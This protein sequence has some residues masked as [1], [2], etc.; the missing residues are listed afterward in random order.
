[1]SANAAPV[2]LALALLVPPALFAQ[3]PSADR[4]TP[5]AP[6][7]PFTRQEL[8]Q[9][10]AEKLF[11]RAVLH[12][13]E[14]RLVEALHTYEEALRFD[15]DAAPVH[16][17]LV[18]LYLA[19]DRGDDALAACRRVLE[20]EPT[21][22][23]TGFL[24]ARQLRAREKSAEAI[25]V[26]TK[27]VAVPALKDQPD[28]HAQVSFELGTLHEAAS[29]W[30]KAEAAFSVAAGILD[31]PAAILELRPFSR[32]EVDTQAAETFERLGRVRLRA[33]KSESAVEAFRQAQKKDP[34]RAAR[35]AYNL[36]EVL[37]SQDRPR[38]ALVSLDEYLRTQ[39]QGTEGYE[40]KVRLLRQLNRGVDVLPELE[41]AAGRDPH[42]TSLK[43]L[44]AREYRRARQPRDAEQVYRRLIV[45]QPTPEVFRELFALYK[46]D[47]RRGG[48]EALRWL[49]ESVS[50]AVEKDN[51]PGDPAAAAHARAI[52]IVLRDDAE[53]VKRM[54]E[55]T[56]RRLLAGVR[57]ENH[58]RVLMGD[59]AYR[60]QQLDAAEELYRSCLNRPGGLRDI[61]HDVY[62]GLLKVLIRAHKHAEIVEVCKQGLEKAHATN[63]LLFHLELSRAQLSLGRTTEALAAVDA[64]VNDADDKN[65]LLCRRNRVE[66]LALTGKYEP[67]IAECQA[68]LKEYNQPG[69]VR[70]IRY[71]LSS[72]YSTARN[73]PRAEEQLEMLLRADPNDATANNDLGYIWADQNKNLD[74]AER[75]IRKALELDRQQRSSGNNVGLDADRDNAAY[76]DSLGWVLFR[77]GELAGAHRELQRASTLSGG[78]DDPVVWDHL[79]DVCFQEGEKSLAA[80]HWKKALKLYDAGMRRPD[81][82]YKDIQKKLQREAP[83]RG[84]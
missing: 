34:T 6:V 64:A 17:A 9:R 12:E 74:E 30:D 24:Y 62:A 32:E 4:P 37:R 58:A 75:M 25:A 60:T 1:M 81:E 51:K 65:R 21:D 73:L 20:L 83:G 68:L 42:N 59:L 10:E 77:K 82:R 18:P 28:L 47:P 56:H 2:V 48:E 7:T 19:L 31:H 76:V 49:D 70:E 29:A 63:R 14:N 23:E 54:L 38:E 13:R 41:T 45:E 5:V 43:L 84:E 57:L 66:I 39:P 67:A 53:L 61:E 11:G 33:G 3:S 8:D 16:R 36:A 69:D 72:V 40:L 46:E 78:A 52:L 44:L 50:K 79:G 27:V 55:A 71:T 26:L 22:V 35:L 80:G 15:P